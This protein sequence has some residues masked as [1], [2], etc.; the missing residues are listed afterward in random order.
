[1]TEYVQEKQLGFLPLGVQIV[2][3]AAVFLDRKS[4]GKF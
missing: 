2:A 4:Y 3:L 1:M